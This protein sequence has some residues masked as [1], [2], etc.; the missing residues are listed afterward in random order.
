LEKTG[1]TLILSEGNRQ[2]ISKGIGLSARKPAK[3]GFPMQY[4]RRRGGFIQGLA[5]R[6]ARE[7]SL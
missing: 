3:G 7:K 6:G 5:K 1:D 2:E 4:R